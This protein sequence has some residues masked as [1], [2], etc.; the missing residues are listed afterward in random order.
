MDAPAPALDVALLGGLAAILLGGTGALAA[1]ADRRRARG[2][3]ILAA[4][5]AAS[6]LGAL[7]LWPGPLDAD[8]LVRAGARLVAAVARR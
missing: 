6:A 7:L 5:G 2:G 1:L 3:L 4:L 8:G